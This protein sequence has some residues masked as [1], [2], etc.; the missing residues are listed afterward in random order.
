MTFGRIGQRDRG[1]GG[2]VDEVE[3]PAEQFDD[4]AEPLEVVADEG[5][6]GVRRS[7]SSLA[8]AQVGHGRQPGDLEPG[9]GRRLDIPAG[10]GARAARRG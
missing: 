9:P 10:V 8:L 3:L 1:E 6:A 7:T 4:A 5:L 2:D